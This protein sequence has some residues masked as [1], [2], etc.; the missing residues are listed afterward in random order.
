M[1]PKL[2]PFLMLA[3]NCARLQFNVPHGY[4]HLHLIFPHGCN[5]MIVLACVKHSQLANMHLMTYCTMLLWHGSVQLTFKKQANGKNATA[6]GNS[7]SARLT[8]V[9]RGGGGD[10]RPY[11]DS[12]PLS[13][14]FQGGREGG[15]GLGGLGVWGPAG[16]RRS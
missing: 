14:H 9:A 6:H 10:N 16:R 11:A 12:L 7:K 8:V 2:H 13:C 4:A 1:A 5:H 3:H 15:A